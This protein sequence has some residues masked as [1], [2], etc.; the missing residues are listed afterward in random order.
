MI[1]S[2]E[3][4]RLKSKLTNLLN[5]YEHS[6]N[7][8]VCK[9]VSTKTTYNKIIYTLTACFKIMFYDKSEIKIRVVSNMGNLPFV[10]QYVLGIKKE[11]DLNKNKDVLFLKNILMHVGIRKE[12]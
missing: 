5:K 7:L 11:F 9:N 4:A 2:K 10:Y 12:S 3:R 8:I 6:T 1:T